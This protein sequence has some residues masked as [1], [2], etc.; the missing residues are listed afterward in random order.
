M[1]SVVILGSTGSIGTQTLDVFRHQP[2]FSV[3][4]LSAG[5]NYELLRKQIAE[6]KPKFAAI[7]SA[8]HAKALREEF[9]IPVS[10]DPDFLGEMVTDPA[11]DLVVVSVVGAVGLKP[12]LLALEAGKRVALANK[13]TLVAGGHLVMNYRDQI[14]P[15]DSEHSALWNLVEGRNR[16]DL[17][18][19][20]LTASGGPFRNYQGS[21]A[22][23]SVEQALKHPRWDMG[24][25]IS[26]DSATLM[27]K[28]LEVIEAHWLFDFPYSQID[29][30]VH[31]ES[32]V[33]SLVQLKDG[34]LL[35]HLGTTDMRLPIQYALTYPEIRRSPV[36]PLDLVKTGNL[37]FD[38]VDWERF[39]S[40]KLA[41]EA[42]EAGG[43]KPIALNAANEEAVAA[44]LRG[45]L[46]F[47]E[48]PEIVGLVTETFRGKSFPTLEQI[49]AIDQEARIRS[50]ALMDKRG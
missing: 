37:S 18:K 35:A 26:I 23:V 36:E 19:L 22:E 44:F 29:V 21:L 38:A 50:R 15:I 42:G 41:Y 31:P 34:A 33:H 46:R 11:C 8:E 48:I 40:L 14:I 1:R 10:S 30:V 2:D 39:P 28:G 47:T 49:L 17:A 24:G 5:S 20:I 9:S 6:F 16:D 45:S 43:E 32:I 25:K 12:T 13:E 7:K 3:R 27:N 4:G